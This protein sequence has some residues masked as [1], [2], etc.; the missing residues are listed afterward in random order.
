MKVNTALVLVTLASISSVAFGTALGTNNFCVGDDITLLGSGYAKGLRNTEKD[1]AEVSACEDQFGK[2]GNFVEELVT[3]AKNFKWL[4]SSSYNNLIT[5]LINL[6]VQQSDV[7]TACQ[8]SKL[9]KAL[10]TRSATFPGA[11][12]LVTTIA[13]DFIKKGTFYQSFQ[14]L[15]SASTQ[16][17]DAVGNAVGKMVYTALQ[18]GPD[19]KIDTQITIT[20]VTSQDDSSISTKPTTQ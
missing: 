8:S 17:C 19:L 10:S 13:Y 14:T 16:T 2:V 5:Q 3:Q 12:D 18:T 20:F 9:T 1:S 15:K 11:L 7:D 6:V 4:E